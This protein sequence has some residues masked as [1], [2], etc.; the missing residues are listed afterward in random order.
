[1]LFLVHFTCINLC[2][3]NFPLLVVHKN[4]APAAPYLRLFTAEQRSPTKKS[5]SLHTYYEAVSHFIYTGDTCTRVL[6]FSTFAYIVDV[7]ICAVVSS[8]CYS[9]SRVLRAGATFFC[10]TNRTKLLQHKLIHVQC[11]EKSTRVPVSPVPQ[12]GYFV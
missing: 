8:P 4:A 2:R 10:T 6:F 7:S 12:Y 1:M 11:T 3:S 9:S 5:S